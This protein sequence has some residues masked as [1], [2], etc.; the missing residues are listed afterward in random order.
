MFV[1][2]HA[3]K[4]ILSYLHPTFYYFVASFPIYEMAIKNA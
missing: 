3:K 4:A 2:V 1:N